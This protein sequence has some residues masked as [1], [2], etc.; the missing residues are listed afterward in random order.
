MYK[1][2]NLFV[3]RTPTFHF[4]KDYTEILKSKTFQEALYLASPSLYNDVYSQR[5]IENNI[6][7]EKKTLYPLI[8]YLNR[9]STRCTPF[10]LFASCSIGEIKNDSKENVLIIHKEIQKYIRLDMSFLCELSKR[11]IQNSEIRNCIYFYSNSTTYRVGRNIRF[12]EKNVKHGLQISYVEHSLILDKILAMAQNGVKIR[13]IT[14]FILTFGISENDAIDY[15]NDL[16]DAQ[17]L[18]SEVNPSI[19][20]SDY[21]SKI[22]EIVFRE[23]INNEESCL[24][25]KISDE[26]NNLNSSNNFQSYQQLINII[27]SYKLNYDENR[28]FQADTKRSTYKTEI[29]S[30]VINDLKKIIRFLC[31]KTQKEKPLNLQKFINAFYERYGEQEVSLLEALDPEIGLGYPLYTDTNYNSPLLE[32][33]QLPLKKGTIQGSNIDAFHYRLSQ[34]IIKA[35]TLQ[36]DVYLTDDDIHNTEIIWNDMPPTIGLM[37]ELIQKQDNDLQLY[38]KSIG[39][40]SGANL[41]AR[42]AYMDKNIEK[43]MKEVSNTEQILN[44]NVIY[45]EIAFLPEERIGNI[46]QRPHTRDYEIVLLTPPDLALEKIIYPSDLSLSFTNGKLCL[47][48]KKLK[49]QIYPRLTTAH[50][51]KNST[52]PIY[53]FLC[54]MQMEEPNIYSPIDL[55]L[56]LSLFNF[57]P[58]IKYGNIIL[59]LATWNVYIKD[60]KY[61]IQITD[62]NKLI[63]ELQLWRNSISLPQ[64]CFLKDNDNTLFID[65][66]NFDIIQSLFSIIKKR[67]NVYLSEFIFNSSSAVVKDENGNSYLNECIFIFQKQNHDSSTNIP[68]RK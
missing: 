66:N 2:F 22:R 24:I 56:L 52:T 3:F 57:I 37:C 65:W 49:K 10:G 59:S 29:S 34:K 7:K 40:G 35:I 9:T 41:L 30:T 38:L 51:F 4:R 68:P 39:G 50:N 13:E 55:E 64:Y 14:N 48:S 46:L 47:K 62:K 6:L 19:T 28:L 12:L 43:I 67:E 36:E 23:K 21:L 26:L 54:E 58:R 32:G 27:N 5:N 17:L 45:A 60:I 63:Y 20:G 33:F 61:L 53:R 11:L 15:I 42:F 44:Q 31:K 18:I 1:P 25:Q 16:I 8:R